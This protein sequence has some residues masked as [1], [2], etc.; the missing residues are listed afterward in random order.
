[1]STCKRLKSRGGLS[2]Q[3][4][5]LQNHINCVICFLFLLQKKKEENILEQYPTFCMEPYKPRLMV[6]GLLRYLDMILLN[7]CD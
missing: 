4:S 1:M 7:V 5:A 2:P 3:L 6:V